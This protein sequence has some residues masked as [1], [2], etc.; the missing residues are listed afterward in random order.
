[1][2]TRKARRRL[3]SVLCATAVGGAL[4]ALSGGPGRRDRPA[5]K[6]DRGREVGDTG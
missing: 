6:K 4:L 5:G 2:T 1:M 3:T